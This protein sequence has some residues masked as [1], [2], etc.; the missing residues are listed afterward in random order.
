[1][2]E[3]ADSRQYD[4]VIMGGGLAGLTLSLQLKKR[5]ADLSILVLER[6]P[7][8]VPLA[9]HK[10]GESSVEIGAHYF[11]TVLGLKEHLHTEQLK[12]FGFRFFFSDKRRDFDQVT[13]LGG[14]KILPTCTYQ[15]DRGIFEN[16]LAKLALDT[17][18]QFVDD[19]VIRQFSISENNAP[20]QVSYESDQQT[21]KVTSRWLIDASGRAGLI[22]RKLDL[23]QT[24]EHNAGAVWFR[25]GNRI[26]INDWSD[27]EDWLT[28]CNPPNRWLSTNHLV[29]EGYWVWLIPLASGSHS[30]GIVAD[31]AL[32]PV[33]SMNT[34]ETAMEWLKIHQPRLFD[35]LDGERDKLQDF[36][37]FK[38]FSYGCKQIFSGEQRWALTGEAGLF[39]D[40]FYSPGS[41]FIAIG[42]TYITELIA[43]DRDKAPVAMY[44]DFYQQIYFSLYQTTLSV[45]VDQYALFGDPE[46]LP[47]KVSWDYAYYWGIM[48]PLFIQNRLTDIS[49]MGRM[50]KPLMQVQKMNVAMQNFFRAWGKVSQ[51]RNPAQLLDQTEI[52]WFAE[53]NR[54]L[55]DELD[56][57]GFAQRMADNFLLLQQLADALIARACSEHPDLAKS[58]AGIELKQVLDDMQDAPYIGVAP[59]LFSNAAYKE[60]DLHAKS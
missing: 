36:A 50:H 37:F 31:A 43:H 45:Y 12:K 49:A 10:V 52:D 47:H 34:F 23:A 57:V 60:C 4:V 24:N 7:H 6:R 13:E 11:D 18:V 58:D 3:T 25:I 21:V 15:I 5:F 55:K 33:E 1:M 44:A 26:D 54:G 53:L 51:K 22:K 29:G 19:A 41:D 42:N 39:L 59:I 48:C 28:S 40:P 56:D 32:H 35:H 38:S 20:H 2:M 8:P 27:N 9:A 14:S 16:K 17:G 30:V 46:V